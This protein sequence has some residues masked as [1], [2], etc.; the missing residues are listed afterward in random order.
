MEE[1]TRFFEIVSGADPADETVFRVGDGDGAIQFRPVELTGA[2]LTALESELQGWEVA[3]RY[4]WRDE[5]YV[6]EVDESGQGERVI[7]FS[8][9]VSFLSGAFTTGQLR[10]GLLLEH[11]AFAGVILKLEN[12]TSYGMAWSRSDGLGVL[13]TDGRKLGRTDYHY[14]HTSTEKAESAEHDYSLRRA[15][16]VTP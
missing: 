10:G 13:L 12:T 14:F 9:I 16:V 15:G 8:K 6:N 7:P 11:G 5:D 2:A 4:K 1:K 3:D